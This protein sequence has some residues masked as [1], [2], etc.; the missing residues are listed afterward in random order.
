MLK[1]VLTFG[2]ALLMMGGICAQEAGNNVHYKGARNG[3][4][5]ITFAA[6]DVQYWVGTGS[7]S[8]VV[9]IGWDDNTNGNF[10]LA[11]GVHWNG[12]ATAVNMLD[13]IATHDSRVQYAISSG[14]VTNIGDNDGTLVSG[15]TAS[16]WCYTLNGGNAGAYGTQAMAN[17]DVMEIS[18]SCMF[19]LTTASAATNPNGTPTLPDTVD[20]AIDP[21]DILYWVGSGSNEAIFIVNWANPDT[22]LAWG[23]RF[24]GTVTAQQMIDSI[25][26]ADPRFWTVGTPSLSGDVHFITSNG[27]TLGLSAVDPNVGYNFWWTNLNG[28]SAGSGTAETLHDGDV[29]KYGD[30]NSATGWD[31]QWGFYMEEAWN[32]IPTPVPD[33][34]NDPEVP[35]SATIDASDI[36]YWVGEGSNEAIFVV[37]WADTALAWGYRFS[38]DSVALS[39]V[40]D[41]I[42]AA[43][44]RF[45]YVE[46]G[47]FINDINF[48]VGTDTLGVAPF[49]WWEHLLNGYSSAGLYS[50]LHDGDFSRWADP[51]AGIV[52]DSFS[53]DWGGTT[54][55]SYI[56]AY[57]QTIV[58]VDDPNE[59]TVGPFCGAVGTEGCTAIAWNDNRIK[60]W[61][62]G[63]TIVRGTE[64]LSNPDAP[65]VTY[66]EE[67]DAIGPASTS[68][69]DVVSLGDGGSATLTFAHPIRNGEG[70]DFAVFENSFN[71]AFLELAFVEVSSDGSHFVRF[72]AT[73]LTQTHTQIAS[74]VD[75]TFINNLAGK[76]RVGYGTPFDLEELRDSANL[77]INNITH[78]RVVDV[79]GSIDPQYGTYDAY[80]HIIN[81]PFPTISY[82]GGFDLD[83]ICVLNQGGE[84]IDGVETASLQVYPNPANSHVTVRCQ[85]QGQASEAV[86]YDMSGR[87]VYSTPLAAETSQLQIA[88]AQL[89]SGVYM[90]RIGTDV[91]KVVVRH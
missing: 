81:D 75:P 3:A 70:Y 86:L 79:V 46:A 15:S 35:E 76:Y 68:T 85:P 56:Y 66:G 67:A 27:D 41:D 49:S 74:N 57:P 9:I 91:V 6:S 87:A 11:W 12:S 36:V 71:D 4:K 89:P 44:P 43:D 53:Y 22:A 50:Q 90:L 30:L 69:M 14:F 73:S 54:Y 51:A 83:G 45:S 24:N 78:V 48:I 33:P 65:A 88:T 28:V 82:S 19:S 25:D 32:T 18:S 64:N 59:P 29:F 16:Y 52:I 72:P 34:F 61:A 58:P 5:S 17:G 23:Y 31:M 38:T 60:G 42:A 47:G 84:G 21:A 55:W 8:A 20:A 13:S 62:T 39:T 77:D 7:N 80:G 37:N 1:K 63:C 40:M 10:A 2:I 26:A